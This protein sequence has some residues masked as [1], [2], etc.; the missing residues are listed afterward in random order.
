MSIE[1]QFIAAVREMRQLQQEFFRDTRN[2]DVLKRAKAAEKH[3]DALLVEM[4]SS[5]ERL[6]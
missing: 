1:Q 6:L 5:Q 4:D 2:K 3:V